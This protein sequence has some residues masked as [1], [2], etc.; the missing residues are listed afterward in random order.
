MLKFKAWL[1]EHNIKQKEVAELL[2]LDQSN[3]NLKLNGKQEFTVHQIKK[4][5]DTYGLIA[6]D[7]FF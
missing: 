1:V 5:C 2:E 4:I 3:L 7:Y 6:N